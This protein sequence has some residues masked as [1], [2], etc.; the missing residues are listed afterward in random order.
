MA[1]KSRYLFIFLPLLGP[2]GVQAQGGSLM[3]Q[4]SFRETVRNQN[5]AGLK[6][7]L[8]ELEKAEIRS[9]YDSGYSFELRPSIKRDEAGVALRFNLAERLDQARLEQ[10]LNLAAMS[11]QYMLDVLEWEEVVSVYREF[12]SYRKFRDQAELLEK[13]CAFVEPYLEKADQ[14]VLDHHLSV[15]DR[16]RF[17]VSYLDILNEL[18]ERRNELH[19]A[20]NALRTILGPTEDLDKLA[21]QAIIVLPENMDIKELVSMALE[22]RADYRVHDIEINAMMLAGEAAKEQEQFRLEFIQP[23]FSV[24]HNEGHSEWELTAS[25]LLPWGVRNPDIPVIRQQME[26]AVAAKNQKERLIE[27]RFKA[28]LDMIESY[29][30]QETERLQRNAPVVSQLE[31]DAQAIAGLPL[32]RAR[33]LIVIH[34]QILKSSLQALDSKYREES[35]AIDLAEQLGSAPYRF[36]R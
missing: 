4:P 29:R 8:A 18:G 25:F 1:I 21:A 17:Y 14:A 28:I 3:E 32:D 24:D 6:A 30:V 13:E 34:E 31:K 11:E 35:L 7:E 5:E 20:E 27:A 26:L 10:Q 33:D 9:D 12:C 16:A 2:L 36:S 22:Q 23:S 15:E 19:D